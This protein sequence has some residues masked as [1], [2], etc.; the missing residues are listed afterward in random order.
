MKNIEK[1]HVPPFHIASAEGKG[2]QFVAWAKMG[3]IL[4]RDPVEEPGNHVWFQIG[5][6]RAQAE[7]KLLHEL[8]VIA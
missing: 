4:G 1:R 3:P 7:A 5:Q 2:G 8:G 6:T